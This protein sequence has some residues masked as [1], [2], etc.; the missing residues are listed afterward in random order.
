ML[1]PLPPPAEFREVT[2]IS[3]VEAAHKV[4]IDKQHEI[5]TPLFRRAR[6]ID[7][8]WIPGQI[9]IGEVVHEQQ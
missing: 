5:M 4:F 8:V 3:A 2:S 9:R 7:K 6:R 1:G